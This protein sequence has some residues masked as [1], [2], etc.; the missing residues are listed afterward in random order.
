MAASVSGGRDRA[1]CALIDGNARTISERRLSLID[2]HGIGVAPVVCACLGFALALGTITRASDTK[3]DSATADF[4]E[5][6]VRPVLV[7]HCYKCHSS[8]TKSLKGGLRLDNLIDMRKGGDT[9]PAVVPGDVEASLLVKA[10]RYRDEE[11]RMPPKGKLPA[12]SIAALE[13]WVKHGAA[14]PAAA[15]PLVPVAKKT[16]PF[17]FESARNHWAYQ[18]VRE[19]KLPAVRR[20]DWPS[21][22]VDSFIL[23]RLE[24][25]R[26]DP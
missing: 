10:V 25:A 23:A 21:T 6:K 1:R 16:A 14:G 9:G 7:E 18:P 17:D 8:Q 13:D 5:S 3:S 19:P 26:L 20:R 22:P 4:F 11:L 12:G 24:A 15:G 2:F